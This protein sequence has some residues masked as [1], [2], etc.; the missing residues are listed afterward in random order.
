[1]LNNMNKPNLSTEAIE[2]KVVRSAS[3]SRG[4]SDLALGGKAPD[5]ALDISWLQGAV[6]SQKISTKAGNVA[7]TISHRLKPVGK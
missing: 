1:M 3:R 6:K 7:A 5:Q 2:G 4:Q